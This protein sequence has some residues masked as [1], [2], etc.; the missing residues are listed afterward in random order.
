MSSQYC[1]VGHGQCVANIAKW[2]TVNVQISYEM[3]LKFIFQNET[4]TVSQNVRCSSSFTTNYLPWNISALDY[5]SSCTSSGY[6]LQVC[7]LNC[8]VPVYPWRRCCTHCYMTF[9][10]A[11]KQRVIFLQIHPK[12]SYKDHNKC[13][14]MLTTSFI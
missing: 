8:K 5:L 9:E 3:T 4:R 12:L 6:I 11:D 1:Q 10:E 14:Q 7:K 2:D 13:N